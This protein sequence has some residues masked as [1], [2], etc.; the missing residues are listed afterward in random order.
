MPWKPVSWKPVSWKLPCVAIAVVASCL[1]FV[2]IVAASSRTAASPRIGSVAAGR[3][4]ESDRPSG[5]DSSVDADPLD[6]GHEIAVRALADAAT[7][8]VVGIGCSGPLRGSG[9][10]VEGE[11]YTNRHLVEMGT[12]VKLD[13]LLDPVLVRLTAKASV[14]D[15]AV[16]PG[17]GIVELDFALVNAD[18]GD[19]VFVAGHAGGGSTVVSTGPVHLYDKT[20]AYGTGGTV[21]LIDVRTEPGFSGGP[22]LDRNGRVVGMLQGFEQAIGLTL[23]IPV[24]DLRAWNGSGRPATDGQCP[25]AGES[26]NETNP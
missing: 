19:P 26:G 6:V 4:S 17:V 25:A 1:A 2:G 14:L 18:V 9:F 21:M 3:P 15:V 11:T 12:E 8:G 7:V 24:E 20:G 10:V 16:A 13:Q 22:V 5:D 23:A